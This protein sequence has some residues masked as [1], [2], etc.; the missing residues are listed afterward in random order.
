MKKGEK[1]MYSNNK[2]VKG[3]KLCK[4]VAKT[5]APYVIVGSIVTA[6]IAYCLR[7]TDKKFKN[8][9]T[10]LDSSLG[11]RQES[12]YGCFDENSPKLAY[13]TGWS[14][15]EDGTYTRKVLKFD[16]SKMRDEDINTL[17]NSV[18]NYINDEK[19]SEED[20]LKN[21]LLLS[22][23][24]TSLSEETKEEL[25]QEELDKGAFVRASVYSIDEND[26]IEYEKTTSQ[27]VGEIALAIAGGAFFLQ[28]FCA[29]NKKMKK[30]NEEAKNIIEGS[31]VIRL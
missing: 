13:Y 21:I 2:I 7:F 10:E 5:A 28:L 6:S 12:Q 30:R 23:S 26:Y 3:L 24:N 4:L 15:K 18:D 22:K 11:M 17:Y 16:V 9:K 1:N 29:D 31:K 8:T 19:V 27:K 20:T 25:S 14:Q